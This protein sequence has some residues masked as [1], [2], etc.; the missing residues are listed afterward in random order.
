MNDLF[1]RV[2][3]KISRIAFPKV[4]VVGLDIQD[5]QIAGVVTVRKGDKTTPLSASLFEIP[6][7]AI[8]RGAVCD[9]EPIQN[10]IQT[11]LNAVPAKHT[12]FS[13][14]PVFILSIPSHHLYAQTEIFPKMESV[15]LDEA[16]RLKIETSMPW[17]IEDTYSHWVATELPEKNE[18]AVFIAA[19]D[20]KTLDEYLRMIVDKGWRVGAC[21]F[22]LLSLATFIDQS[23]I[24]SFIFA[25]LD[26]DGIEFGVFAFGTIIAHFL[27]TVEQGGSAKTI[28]EDKIKQLT[29]YV[30]GD[31]GIK[32][33]RIF[34][35]NRSDQEDSLSEI[36]NITGIPTQLFTT[37]T[38]SGMSDPRLLIAQ[39]AAFRPYSTFESA[40]NLVPQELGG[41]YQENLLL[42]TVNL[43]TKILL[44]FSF[45]FVIAFGGVF[46]FL[47]HN[48]VD[49]RK[50]LQ[51]ATLIL[52]RFIAQSQPLIHEAQSF[53]RL[54]RAFTM[55]K[56][57]RT[58]TGKQLGNILEILKDTGLS[59]T[60]LNSSEN[61]IVTG[62]FQA[63]TRDAVME[64]KRRMESN[65]GMP[66][67][68]SIP[69]TDL[70]KDTNLSINAV[71]QFINP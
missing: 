34:I 67:T 35:F 16:I 10:A 32:I 36:K 11:L 64:F 24:K 45:S 68:V 7:S 59:V 21:E 28:L 27:H 58:A 17:P 41:R 62:I 70:S 47:R 39:G 40:V 30:E 57:I 13:A 23:N 52:N 1:S 12:K 6:E 60:S 8:V 15:Q 29:S 49:L 44:V 55:S 48:S 18:T 20:K 9:P 65:E 71:I 63:P 66:A 51:E 19:I 42:K 61:G 26:E 14:E 33:D 53:N 3:K 46:W 43:W 56:G 2:F 5:R 31:F 54:T 38:Q 50:N 25:L 22:H 69:L 37:E 4:I